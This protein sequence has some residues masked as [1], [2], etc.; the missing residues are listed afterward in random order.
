MRF[1]PF[2]R[3]LATLGIGLAAVLGVTPVAAG[4]KVVVSYQYY[5]VS[6]KTAL[7]LMRNLHLHGPTV[8][9]AGAYATIQSAFSESG[10]VVQGKGCRVPRYTI[11]MSFTITLPVAQDLPEASPRVRKAWQ[12]F[13]NF[14]KRH[15]ETHKAIWVGCATAM[16][17]QVRA[18]SARS[19]E[20]LQQ[21]AAQIVARGQAQCRR[22]QDAFDRS[23]RS[24][25]KAQPLLQ[26]ALRALKVLP[27]TETCAE[28]RGEPLAP[29]PQPAFFCSAPRRSSI[30]RARTAAGRARCGPT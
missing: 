29:T 28:P 1:K 27:A 26:Q 17:A 7:E 15:E 2:V 8:A 6:G 10:A 16:Q 9:G 14:V 12:S 25:L 3:R 20:V 18:L 23:E 24:R 5:P 4:P 11:G 30:S 21:R 13:Y 19:C 22:K